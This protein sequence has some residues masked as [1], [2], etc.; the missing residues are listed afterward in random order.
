MCSRKTHRSKTLWFAVEVVCSEWVS[1]CRCC[2]PSCC[3]HASPQ[4]VWAGVKVE[5]QVCCQCST[6]SLHPQLS[7]VGQSKRFY[8]ALTS[9][10][11]KSW[12]LLYNCDFVFVWAASPHVCCSA[13]ILF[14]SI[15][16]VRVIWWIHLW[17]NPLLIF[18][19]V[20]LSSE[21]M[22]VTVVSPCS[23]FSHQSS[24]REINSIERDVF[25]KDSRRNCSFN[26]E[27]RHKGKTKSK[28]WQ[29]NSFVHFL[30]WRQTLPDKCHHQKFNFITDLLSWFVWRESG[31]WVCLM[32]VCFKQTSYYE[33]SSE[34]KGEIPV[35]GSLQMVEQIIE[36]RWITHTHGG[37]STLS[38]S[39]FFKAL[40]LCHTVGQKREVQ[41]LITFTPL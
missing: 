3:A 9:M 24:D 39:V 25:I 23:S 12:V 21:E 11:G 5:Q 30:L 33:E 1:A 20:L 18:F 29:P 15:L 13:L 26:L 40:M 38:S 28:D 36:R 6:Q 19:L 14:L 10:H 37:H 4:V 17:T 41:T 8:P 16:S 35:K 2:G 7:R 27:E 32:I 31:L 34:G 22:C